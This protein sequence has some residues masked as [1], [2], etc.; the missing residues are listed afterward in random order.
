MRRRFNYTE[1]QRIPRDQ[2]LIAVSEGSPVTFDAAFELE[3][4]DF[5]PE[6]RVIVEAYRQRFYSRFDFGPVSNIRAPS[7]RRIE[8]AEGLEQIYFRVKVVDTEEARGRILGL[9]DKL[10]PESEAER[11]KRSIFPV[12]WSTEIENAIWRVNYDETGRP[13][14]ELNRLISDLREAFQHD[15]EVRALIL[16]GALKDVLNQ[17]AFVEQSLRAGVDEG[18]EGEW[19]AFIGRFYPSEPP[20]ADAPRSERQRWVEDV[21]DAFCDEFD[22]RS[23]FEAR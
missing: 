13:T 15:P 11:E 1:R 6:A 3:D 22:P 9:A 8:G 16:P 20:P 2:V 10:S 7:D 23:L 18:W 19:L 21:V 5:Q 17:I 14:L 12:F 4:C